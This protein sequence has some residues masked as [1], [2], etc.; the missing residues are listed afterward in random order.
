MWD[1]VQVV[2]ALYVGATAPEVPTGGEADELSLKLESIRH[3]HRTL[4]T[5]PKY[6]HET[7]P[8]RGTSEC[9]V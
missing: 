7:H 9:A 2:E 8:E 4:S 1:F 5:C 6:S 3:Q